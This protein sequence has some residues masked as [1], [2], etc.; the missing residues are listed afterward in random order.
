V[1]QVCQ[2]CQINFIFSYIRMLGDSM[3]YRLYR[4]LFRLVPK[5]VTMKH[6]AGK[7]RVSNSM[8]FI[9]KNR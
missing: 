7:G 6:R 3:L 1:C 5:N 2:L 8:I 4:L 9:G